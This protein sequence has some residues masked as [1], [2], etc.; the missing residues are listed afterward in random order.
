MF[1]ILGNE[2]DTPSQLIVNATIIKQNNRKKTELQ[3]GQVKSETPRGTDRVTL[4]FGH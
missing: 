3:S 2:N 4:H 1:D